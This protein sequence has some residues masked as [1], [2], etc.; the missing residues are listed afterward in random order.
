MKLVTH[1]LIITNLG[2]LTKCQ[3]TQDQFPFPPQFQ[4]P[5]SGIMV[6]DN[7]IYLPPEP[8]TAMPYFA[9]NDMNKLP[10][11]F[12]PPSAT[13][14]PSVYPS[15]HQVVFSSTMRPNFDDD[16][17]DDEHQIRISSPK[18]I[19]KQNQGS[20][21]KNVTEQMHERRDIRTLPKMFSFEQN[22]QNRIDGKQ[23]ALF[24]HVTTQQPLNQNTASRRMILTSELQRNDVNDHSKSYNSQFS[25]LPNI[26]FSSTTEPSIPILR[27]SNEMDLDGSFSYEA[28]GADQTH[29]VQH[30]RMENMGSGKEEQVVEGS[31]SYVGDNG[32]TYTV[33][34]IADS[35]GYRASGDHLPSPPPIPE[36]IQRAVQYNLAEEARRPPNM[37]SSWE[38]N[39][40]DNENNVAD[41]VS[42]Y[43]P[44]RGLF[45]GK[46]PEAFSFGFTQNSN[47]Q[48]NQIVTAAPSHIPK[49]N[50]DIA[51]ELSKAKSIPISPQITFSA[52]QGTRNPSSTSQSQQSPSRTISVEKQTLPQIM[53]YEA[54]SRDMDQENKPF[55]RWQ[56]GM[57]VNNAE[58][59]PNKNTIS[60]S[61]AEGDDVIINFND[62]TPQ[63]YTDM[64]QR[65]FLV[66]NGG[67]V[68][69]NSLK[70]FP[71]STPN[72]IV[73]KAPNFVTSTMKNYNEN[74]HQQIE[75]STPK[76]NMYSYANN[77]QDF[78]NM[79]NIQAQPEISNGYSTLRTEHVYTTSTESINNNNKYNEEI[80][81]QTKNQTPNPYTGLIRQQHFLPPNQIVTR[82]YDYEE[83]AYE[84]EKV[85]KSIDLH[86]INNERHNTNQ[87]NLSIPPSSY[88][89]T[90]NDISR[91]TT[92][93]P[94]QYSTFN[95]IQST[96]ITKTE[97]NSSF[98]PITFAKDQST[99]T[100]EKSMEELL[101][102]NIFLKNIFRSK[103]EEIV[104]KYE[105]EPKE[106]K[107]SFKNEVKIEKPKHIQSLIKPQKELKT[108][109]KK[110]DMNDVL[111]YIAMK[112]HFEL[113]KTKPKS[114]SSNNYQ[115][116]PS[117]NFIPLREDKRESGERVEHESNTH[118]TVNQQQ[119]ELQGMIKNYKVLQ[120]QRNSGQNLNHYAESQ[121]RHVKTFQSD[122]LP[123]LGRAG[124]SMKSYLPPAYL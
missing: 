109:Q 29:Y 124:P 88:W 6:S 59:N 32:Q 103:K 17:D 4:T 89:Q 114:L 85:T 99:T 92:A 87:Q 47:L 46:T 80:K 1:F 96:D 76:S 115:N 55:W 20:L 110:L 67:P 40:S 108:L 113:A 44:T 41:K 39:D 72:S 18:P 45:T 43:A 105:A 83:L 65:Q 57:N 10:Y 50:F 48:N 12:L 16:D 38:E 30:S 11:Q 86:F 28:L 68:Y 118:R 34:Y 35:N 64:I 107:N 71:T 111:N 31:Y 78:K 117:P 8:H 5:S 27:L 36:I 93:S 22:P 75:Y 66:Q 53:N 37:R 42:H 61:F 13:K 23:P 52:S 112:N 9:V 62:M 26:F 24:Q 69:D 70:T 98:R 14:A 119:E 104:E 121:Q 54:N 60:R 100:T 49:T 73:T 7:S 74:E 81:I 84:P 63:Q 3:R 94:F 21:P 19:F 97:E 91:T 58:Q 101:Q 33:H 56:Y 116:K 77:N 79:N 82:S 123:P 25:Q 95:N 15:A 90:F 106:E 2:V 120:R 51:V 102:E 122:S